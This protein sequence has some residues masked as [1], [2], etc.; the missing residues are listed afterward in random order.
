MPLTAAKMTSLNCLLCPTN[1]SKP[2]A[3]KKRKAANVHILEDK[4][5][6]CSIFTSLNTD[7]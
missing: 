6:E 4:I 3:L 1:S 2:K 5:K 7:D